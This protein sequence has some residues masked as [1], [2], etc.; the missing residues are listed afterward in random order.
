MAIAEQGKFP[1]DRIDDGDHRRIIGI[2]TFFAQ[3]TAFDV[4]HTGKDAHPP[5]PVPT[6]GGPR[7]TRRAICNGVPVVPSSRWPAVLP[8]PAVL[9]TV[10][11]VEVVRLLSSVCRTVQVV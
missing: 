5:N 2:Q 10:A 6:A 1:A 3:R 9:A 8:S 4:V 7:V 11:V